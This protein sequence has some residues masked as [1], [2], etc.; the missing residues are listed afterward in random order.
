VKPMPSDD[1][2][3]DDEE[4]G[5]Q[6]KLIALRAALAHGMASGVAPEGTM[7]RI[8]QRIQTR[9]AENE[10]R[11]APAILDLFGTMDFDPAYDYRRNR[12]LDKIE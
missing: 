2:N 1:H 7:E 6:A 9:G 3:M 12:N 4:Q 5:N 11:P 8:R 10:G